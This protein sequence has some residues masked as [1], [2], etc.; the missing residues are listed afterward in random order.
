[1][2]LI[3]DADADFGATSGRFVDRSR[4]LRHGLG[5]RLR[6]VSFL[7]D[8]LKSFD[9]NQKAEH[10]ELVLVAVTVIGARPHR[11]S[12]RTRPLTEIRGRDYI[13]RII[14]FTLHQIGRSARYAPRNGPC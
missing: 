7:S 13:A 9:P 5:G 14:R 3:R 8:G 1:M 2:Q 6:R 10:I 11:T 4:P 12:T